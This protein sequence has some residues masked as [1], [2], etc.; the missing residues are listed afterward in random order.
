MEQELVVLASTAGN[1]LATLLATDSWERVKSSLMSLWTRHHPRTATEF[2]DLIRDAYVRIHSTPEAGRA[3]IS[4]EVAAGLSTA[5]CELLG[6]SR[7]P[8]HSL[9][10]L[11]DELARTL[12]RR[13]NRADSIEIKAS[14]TG[15]GTANVVGQG[16]IH[17]K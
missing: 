12:P 10:D 6:D 3:A 5:I 8:L 2:E 16:E 17:V 11:V 1:T 15:H 13:S 9:R 14:V 4:T 7:E